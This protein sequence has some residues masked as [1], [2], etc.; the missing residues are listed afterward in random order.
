M[1]EGPELQLCVRERERWWWH[2]RNFDTE[3]G[4]CERRSEAGRQ[5]FLHLGYFFFQGSVVVQ[6]LASW[7]G[8][9]YFY[10]R[11]HGGPGRLVVVVA[12]WI[13]NEWSASFRSSSTITTEL[14]GFWLTRVKIWPLQWMLRNLGPGFVTSVRTTSAIQ[15]SLNLCIFHHEFLLC[16]LFY[17]LWKAECSGCNV[18]GPW[19]SRN[20]SDWIH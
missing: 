2:A 17:G 11:L 9:N 14:R 1:K 19:W 8:W 12:A 20:W 7:R 10:Y 3:F 18:C 6:A 5:T 15:V 13:M 16:G 4:F